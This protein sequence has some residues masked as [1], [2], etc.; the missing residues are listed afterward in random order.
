MKAL[1]IADRVWRRCSE[2]GDK[3]YVLSSLKPIGTIF[4]EHLHDKILWL[5]EHMPYLKI[6]DILISVT[7]K[8]DAVEYVN[9]HTLTANDI[10]IDDYNK[11][12]VEWQ[13]AGGTSV[14]YCNG[15]NSHLSWND[16]CIL[17]NM[18]VD[19]AYRLLIYQGF[20]D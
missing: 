1:K 6:E 15:I 9:G 5:K 10:L 18:P 12:L 2:C 7:D 8:R 14:K 13:A 19:D 20:T 17:P 3:F 11:N 4:N 16:Q